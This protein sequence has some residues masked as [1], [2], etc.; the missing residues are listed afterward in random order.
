MSTANDHDDDGEDFLVGRISRDIPESHAGDAGSGKVE[1]A[2][3]AGLV[4]RSTRQA[5][6][7]VAVSTGEIAGGVVPDV[8]RQGRGIISTQQTTSSQVGDPTLRRRHPLE[9]GLQFPAQSEQPAVLDAAD[10][11][12]FPDGI[13]N[14]GQPVSD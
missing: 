1:R 14:A 11:F 13:P 6:I 10:R 7:R 3:V 5:P 9:G 8:P 4:R 2:D 12:A